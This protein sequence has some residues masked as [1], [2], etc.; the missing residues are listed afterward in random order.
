M[1]GA[2][3]AGRF[4]QAL[5][6]EEGDGMFRAAVRQR[7]Q[8]RRRM[9][10]RRAEA[11]KQWGAVGDFS[12]G[13]AEARSGV[14]SQSFLAKGP[15][16]A[17]SALERASLSPPPPDAQAEAP[18]WDV[19]RALANVGG[20]HHEHPGASL[21][22]RWTSPV[23]GTEQ[24]VGGRAPR[25]QLSVHDADGPR[26]QI[27]ASPPLWDV[28]RKTPPPQEEEILTPHAGGEPRWQPSSKSPSWRHSS[29]TSPLPEAPPGGARASA[30]PPP[31]LAGSASPSPG[32]APRQQVETT[33]Q[34]GGGVLL[35]ADLGGARSHHALDNQQQ[36]QHQHHRTPLKEWAAGRGGESLGRGGGNTSE[37]AIAHQQQRKTTLETA[38]A[39]IRSPRTPFG[40]TPL[41]TPGRRYG[42]QHAAS[43]SSAYH[44]IGPSS[45]ASAHRFLKT[46]GGAARDVGGSCKTPASAAKFPRHELSAMGS[47][48]ISARVSRSQIS[49]PPPCHPS[50]FR[51]V[52]GPLCSLTPEFTLMLSVSISQLLT[53]HRSL[54][55]NLPLLLSS[56]LQ[57]QLNLGLTLPKSLA[58]VLI[59]A[60][61]RGHAVRRT[62]PMLISF[63]H[64]ICAIV[65]SQGQGK[66]PPARPLP[67]ARRGRFWALH[68]QKEHKVAVKSSWS[69]RSVP[70]P[71][72][73]ALRTACPYSSCGVEPVFSVCFVSGLIAFNMAASGGVAPLDRKAEVAIARLDAI[74]EERQMM[75][76]LLIQARVRGWLTRRRVLRL[77]VDSPRWSV[78]AVC[79]AL[80]KGRA[81]VK[82][83]NGVMHSANRATVQELVRMAR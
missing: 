47:L 4:G 6:R 13:T 19:G 46:P 2:Y 80:R 68:A 1:S 28:G 21:P 45:E 38:T 34:H 33:P 32:G 55:L 3:E 11:L 8:D 40:F 50:P 7:E 5:W 83:Y 79:Q 76:I 49:S 27:S 42:M 30:S 67:G 43:P 74:V 57:V 52:R 53:P 25:R 81:A 75:M 59:Q 56:L 82:I 51:A 73:A 20:L 23:G 66:G 37:A 70:Y 58:A 72:P 41:R 35:P 26:R 16:L 44:P 64:R 10:P 60:M 71:L 77:L 65:D 39:S 48:A 22:R 14:G 31:A 18:H 69:A 54:P 78:R 15:P 63:A 12:V 61:W 9:T 24:D 29:M 17:I 62:L 36:H